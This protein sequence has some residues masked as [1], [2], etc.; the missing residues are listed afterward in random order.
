MKILLVEDMAGFANPIRQELEAQ[1]HTVTWIIGAAS[2]DKTGLTGILASR[3]LEPAKED[4]WNGDCDRLIKV[5]FEDIEVALV[6]GGLIGP[7]KDGEKV[8][9]I[10]CQSGIPCI[11]I[12]GG[13]AGLKLLAEAGAAAGLPKEFVVLALKYGA[14]N[15]PVAKSNACGLASV[16]ADFSQEMRERYSAASKAGQKFLTGYPALDAA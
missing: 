6:D 10:L 13:G 16:L 15:M 7:I 4:S 12:T 9:R 11:S 3:D 8:V 5:R 2:A 14:L 1:G